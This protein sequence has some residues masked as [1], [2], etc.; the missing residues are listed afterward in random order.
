[1]ALEV[2]LGI[3]PE[4]GGGDHTLILCLI[5]SGRFRVT[6]LNP[7]LSYSPAVQK[8]PVPEKQGLLE[9]YRYGKVSVLV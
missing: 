8:V 5:G 1:M 2:Q 9:I 7:A 3:F 6:W 4:E